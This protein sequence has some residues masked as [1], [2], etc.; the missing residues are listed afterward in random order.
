MPEVF[1]KLAQVVLG[2]APTTIYTVPAATSAIVKAIFITNTGGA[3]NTVRLWQSGSADGN[4][5]LNPTTMLAGD[6]A[7]YDGAIPMAAGDTLVGSDSLG[8]TTVTVE[9]LEIT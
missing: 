3:P 9:G 5:I 6:Y 1:K 4:A 2:A 7:T 8:A